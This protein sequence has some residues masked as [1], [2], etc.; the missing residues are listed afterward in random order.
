MGVPC[1]D[2]TVYYRFNLQQ[3][4]DDIEGA[5]REVETMCY[6]L[7]DRAIADESIFLRM[8]IPEIH[9]DYISESWRSREKD[10]YGRMDFSYDGVGKP[11]LLEYNADT[12]TTLYE[13]AVFQ[14]VWF[15]QAK[16]AGIVPQNGDQFAEI[17]E[18]LVAAFAAIGLDGLVHFT[19]LGDIEDDRETIKYL[20]EAAAEAG[21]ETHFLAVKDIGVDAEGRFT[22]L[23]DRVIS[24]LFKLYPWEWLLSE[25]FGEHLAGSGVRFIEPP[26][27]SVLSN[28]GL[29][30]HLWEMFEDHPNL[31]PA[32]FEDEPGAA[33][34]SGDYVRKPIYS[35]RG[36]NVQI[37][38]NE[39][40]LPANTGTYGE[41]GFVVQDFA[42]LPSFDGRHPVVGCWMVAGQPAGLS[43]RE[44][45]TLVTDDMAN[46][47][48]HVILD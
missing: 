25:P 29:L 39:T 14:W 3:I 46:F 13:S 31:L 38:K 21:L 2:E 44:S 40:A 32:Y 41:E 27:K 36:A 18:D 8:A 33:N 20:E 22:D 26:W 6:A 34:I 12:P 45:L 28:K 9:W 48:P 17:H 42:P 23:D 11:K 37:I 10:L 43:I 4:E 5:A 16:A 19:C 30:P 47:V 7:L 35:R 24:T 15:E 1:W